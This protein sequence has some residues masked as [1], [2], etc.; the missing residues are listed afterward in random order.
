[1]IQAVKGTKDI[2]N[3]DIEKFDYV[4]KTAERVFQKMGYKHIISPTFE[5]TALFKRGIGEGTD[6]VSKEMYTFEDRGKRSL[7][8]RPE[9]TAGIMRSYIEHNM[10]R[11]EKL[12]KLFYW[13]PMFRAENVQAGRYREFNQFGVEAIGVDS[14]YLDA[15][16][17][18]GAYIFL[19]ELNL[20]E[21]EIQINSVGC[22]E[23]RK[24]YREKLLEFLQP[25]LEHL[26]KDCH[27]RYEKN[28]LRVLDCKV[29]RCKEE[30]VGAPVMIDYLCDDCREHFDKA[31][32]GL[33]IFGVPYV[34]NTRLVRGLD[35]YTNTAF[36][37]VTKKLGAQGTVLAGGRYNNLAEQIGGKHFPAVG[38][39]AGIERLS[40]ILEEVKLKA[41]KKAFIAIIGE[42]AK[43]FGLSVVKNIRETGCYAEFDTEFRSVKAQMKSADKIKADFTLIIGGDEVAK[44]GAVIKN[45]KTGEQEFKNIDDIINILKEESR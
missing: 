18:H 35:Y 26:C 19:N 13:G 9:G 27:V 25:K 2:F 43:Q 12:S 4:V 32:E 36:E 7:T 21:L 29:D 16:L 41:E 15:E 1:M 11:D 3:E 42:E 30:T 10:S 34:I 14:P 44:N 20:K 40:M 38:F 37:I 22:P 8:L 45:M 17:I 33:D 6:I 23:C 28:P 24:V 39:A 5:E 31:K